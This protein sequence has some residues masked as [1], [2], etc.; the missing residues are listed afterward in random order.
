MQKPRR[1]LLAERDE[2]ICELVKKGYTYR[3]VGKIVKLSY[4]R[5]HQIYRKSYPQGSPNQL[6][7][8]LTVE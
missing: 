2:K 3:E 6:D 5:V 1:K 7:K 8:G 4:E